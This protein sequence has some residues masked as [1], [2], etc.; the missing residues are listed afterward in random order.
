MNRK[1]W[2]LSLAAFVI[3]MSF[4]IML[5]ENF[6][7]LDRFW[8][9]LGLFGTVIIALNASSREFRYGLI[10]VALF[11]LTIFGYLPLPYSWLTAHH[12]YFSLSLIA[13]ALTMLVYSVL[14]VLLVQ[15]L[16]LWVKKRRLHA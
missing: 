6:V 5:G 1:D 15:R 13:T 12:I 16:I 14:T 10:I 4:R 2:I 11:L 9:L 8:W 3:L 7:T